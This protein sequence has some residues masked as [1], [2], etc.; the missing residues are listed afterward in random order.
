MA[1]TEDMELEDLIFLLLDFGL[2]WFHPSVLKAQFLQLGMEI[3]IRCDCMLKV[4]ILF[5]IYLYSQ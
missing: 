1:W 4:C 3:F 2:D 5:V